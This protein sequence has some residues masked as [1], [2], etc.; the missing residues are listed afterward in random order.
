MILRKTLKSDLIIYSMALLSL[1]ACTNTIPIKITG[2]SKYA[3]TGVIRIIN[4]DTV[5]LAENL[6]RGKFNLKGNIPAAG[7]YTVELLIDGKPDQSSAHL[8][9]LDKNPV[10]ISYT[11][12]ND[13]Y[14]RITSA[15]AI[16]KDVNRYHQQL[17]QETGKAETEYRIA[18]RNAVETDKAITTEQ[19]AENMNLLTAAE[20][21]LSQVPVETS[22][23]FIANN[24]ASLFSAYLLSGP[25]ISIENTPQLYTDLFEKLSAENKKNSYAIQVKNNIDKHKKN[26]IGSKLPQIFG[27]MPD[28]K[29]FDPKHLEAKVTMVMF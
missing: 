7:F 19:Y 21:N 1:P 2:D 23:K 20:S 17:K 27:T 29:P 11:K 18:Q 12:L 5:L 24:P 3:E 14:P 9:Y 16:Q 26:G 15:S 22:T 8:I 28:D 6:D 4:P 10:Q 13:F 25:V